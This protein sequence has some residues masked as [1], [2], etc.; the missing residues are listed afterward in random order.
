MAR[1]PRSAQGFTWIE[2][3]LVIAVVAALALMAIP[4]LQDNALK[5]QVKEGL[6]L[7]DIAK[8]GVESAYAL[9][10]D[11]PAD[12]K[13]AGIPESGKI[14]GAFV[15][16]VS[17]EAGAITLT[18]GNNASKAIEDRKVTLR[19]AVVPTEP[20]VPIAWL[21]HDVAVPKQME[22]RGKDATDIPSNWLP[23]ECRGGA[24]K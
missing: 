2:M 9:T 14:V 11:M 23:V 17:V 12:N 10:G 15:K 6:A 19:P 22:V 16:N 7:A 24:A 20:L 1:K 4:S 3:L 8:R 21:C 18:Y 13:A 5:R